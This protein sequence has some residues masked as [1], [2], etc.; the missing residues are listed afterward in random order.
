MSDKASFGGM[1][2]KLKSRVIISAGANANFDHFCEAFGFFT[3]EA[4]FLN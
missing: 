2:M 4:G 1:L 3:N